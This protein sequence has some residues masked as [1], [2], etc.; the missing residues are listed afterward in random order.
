MRPQFDLEAGEERLASVFRATQLPSVKK[1]V[2]TLIETESFTRFPFY[3]R[4]RITGYI[5]AYLYRLCEAIW[6]E[7]SPAQL[8]V[9][10]EA[11]LKQKQR[12]LIAAVGR[13]LH[14]LDTQK[15]ITETMMDSAQF[16]ALDAF[17]EKLDKRSRLHEDMALYLEHKM[18][19]QRL[20]VYSKASFENGKSM[21]D[22][23]AVLIENYLKFKEQYYRDQGYDVFLEY[24]DPHRFEFYYR[25]DRLEDAHVFEQLEKEAITFAVGQIM[26][27]TR[28]VSFFTTFMEKDLKEKKAQKDKADKADKADKSDR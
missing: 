27:G 16:R 23:A 6:R 8:G 25:D 21:T 4:H 3:L 11:L 7:D 26:P 15:V 9:E 24:F 18:N 5:T 10:P 17:F 28:N 20:E 13:V 2:S 12:T 14:Q 22:A 1:F 19:L